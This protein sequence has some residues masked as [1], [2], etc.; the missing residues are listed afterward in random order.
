MGVEVER[1]PF[2]QRAGDDDRPIDQLDP[3]LAVAETVRFKRRVPLRP[4]WW[5]FLRT[6]LDVAL[7]NI[8]RL[9]ALC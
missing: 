4:R 6:K 8:G 2:A 5:P 3:K 9:V 7:Q 1:L